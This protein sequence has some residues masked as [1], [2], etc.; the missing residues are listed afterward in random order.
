MSQHLITETFITHIYT[1]KDSCIKEV[2][3]NTDDID[4]IL[5]T[6][7]QTQ[8]KSTLVS[9]HYE[10]KIPLI[11][12]IKKDAYKYKRLNKLEYHFPIEYLD[13][14]RQDANN[15]YIFYFSNKIDTE[16]DIEKY[17]DKIYTSNN[18]HNTNIKNTIQKIGMNEYINKIQLK[19]ERYSLTPSIISMFKMKYTISSLLELLTNGRYDDYKT[20]LSSKENISILKNISRNIITF[21]NK[22]VEIMVHL[23]SHKQN[24]LKYVI[25][26]IE[27]PVIEY[28][29]FINYSLPEFYRY[30]YISIYNLGLYINSI[31]CDNKDINKY[32]S[33]IKRLCNDGSETDR[34][35][36]NV[37][38]YMKEN[39]SQVM[40]G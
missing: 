39:I 10:Y 1:E 2:L 36:S 28:N 4:Y 18:K 24:K 3:Y 19:H 7:K 5:F 14:I 20:E 29:K 31:I 33:L 8:I 9:I 30:D 32:T 13:D 35:H 17:K 25:S 21:L 11:G 15:N 22:L 27:R 12:K 26:K 40:L 23:E 34:I 37:K 16:K 6:N 38:C